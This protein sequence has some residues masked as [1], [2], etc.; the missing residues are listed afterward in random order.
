MHLPVR[1]VLLFVAGPALLGACAANT[2][3][4]TAAPADPPA[5]APPTAV[6]PPRCE[7]LPAQGKKPELPCLPGEAVPA[8][9]IV[10]DLKV[11]SGPPAVAGEILNVDYRGALY[12]GGEFDNSY[13]RGAP[14]P[15]EL[16]QQRVIAGWDE[17]L[18]GMKAGGRRV[19]F[20]PP[21]KGYGPSGNGPIPPDATLRFVVE[22]RSIG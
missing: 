3:A 8:K 6:A 1:R 5:S 15:V 10:K 17:G 9:L 22:L 2:T 14:L 20:I 11:G 21:D 13:D 19:L 4:Q 16:G 18:V 7:V 12:L